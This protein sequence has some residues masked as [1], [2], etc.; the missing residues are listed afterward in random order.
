MEFWSWIPAS[1]L[2][3]R[4]PSLV[5]G[6]LLAPGYCYANVITN[7][8]PLMP[9]LC[10]TWLPVTEINKTGLSAFIEFY[11]VIAWTR[12]PPPGEA[13]EYWGL[14]CSQPFENQYYEIA[15]RRQPRIST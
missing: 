6:G 8:N 11:L 2:P 10:P 3:D 5:L 9:K 4:P 12:L 14:R 13:N 15:S 7:L 1:Q